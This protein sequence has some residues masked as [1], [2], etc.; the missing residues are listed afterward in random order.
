LLTR[1]FRRFV[2]H[3]PNAKVRRNTRQLS[4]LVYV[5]FGVSSRICAK[6]SECEGS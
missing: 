3:K 1:G 5:R 2:A 6:T 4:G